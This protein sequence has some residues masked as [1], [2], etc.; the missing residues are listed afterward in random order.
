VCWWCVCLCRLVKSVSVLVSGSYIILL[1]VLVSVTYI[2][3]VF[4]EQNM[5]Q[6]I[7]EIVAKYEDRL[8]E[9]QSVLNR[10]FLTCLFCHH[11]LAIQFLKDVGPIRSKVECNTC[12]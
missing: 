7:K 10:I 12:E 6:C 9:M 11:K 2:I 1:L 5:V 8:R 4:R 3:P